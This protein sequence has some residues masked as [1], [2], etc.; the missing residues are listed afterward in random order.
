MRNRQKNSIKNIKDFGLFLKLNESIELIP[1][2]S[3]NLIF[4][5]LFISLGM[6]AYFFWTEIKPHSIPVSVKP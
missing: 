6:T 5:Y 3:L 1:N 2:F 4:S